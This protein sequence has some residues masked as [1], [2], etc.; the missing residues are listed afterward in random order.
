[1][2]FLLDQGLPRSTVSHL[3]ALGVT[4]HHVG[5]KGMANATDQAILDEAQSTGAVVV[6]LDADFHSLLAN[7][8]AHGPSVIRLRIE[9]LKGEAAAKLINQVIQATADDLTFGSAVS[10]TSNRISIRRL[11]L[12]G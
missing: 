8:G 9:G 12:R 3:A 4:A 2:I 7:S 1:M 6:T 11:P 10:V 5:E